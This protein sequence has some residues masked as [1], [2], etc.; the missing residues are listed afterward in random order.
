MNNLTFGN[1]EYQYYET[2]GGGTGAGPWYSGASAI[3]SHMTNSRLTD[4]EILEQRFPV[5]LEVFAIREG[6]GG[7]GY[8]RGGDGMRRHICFLQDMQLSILSNRRKVAPYGLAGGGFGAVGRQWLKR[9]DGSREE[10]PYSCCVEIKAG[11]TFCIETPGGG[12]YGKSVKN[13]G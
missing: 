9:R 7:D 12:G 3:H 10:L 5:R 13:D 11:D 8:H 2:I 4:P 6:S 1:M